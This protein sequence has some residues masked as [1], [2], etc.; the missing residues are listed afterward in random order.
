[1]PPKHQ[2]KCPKFPYESTRLFNYNIH[3]QKCEGPKPVLDVASGSGSFTGNLCLQT[4]STK[5][6]LK[7]H[8]QT[9]SCVKRARELAQGLSPAL[10]KYRKLRCHYKPIYKNGPGIYGNKYLLDFEKLMIV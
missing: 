3:V 7:R 5:D 2:M 9:Q 4:V 6:A 1:M 10:K 8:Q